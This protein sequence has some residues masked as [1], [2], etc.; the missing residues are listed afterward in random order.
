[1]AEADT[2]SIARRS[3][4]CRDRPV[5]LRHPQITN[6][7]HPSRMSPSFAAAVSRWVG[8]DILL[9]RLLGPWRTAERPHML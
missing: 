5:W 6:H 1:M 9:E 2:P 3:L 4:V 7:R 8:S